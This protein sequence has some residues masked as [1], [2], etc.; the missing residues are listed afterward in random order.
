MNLSPV[1]GTLTTM[2]FQLQK[3]DVFYE[4]YPMNSSFKDS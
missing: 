4:E 3:P 2:W 1:K